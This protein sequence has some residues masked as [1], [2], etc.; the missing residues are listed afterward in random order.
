MLAA[1]GA[2][3]VPLPEEPPDELLVEPDD[4]E[5]GELDGVVVPEEDES[6]SPDLLVLLDVLSEP[7]ERES[8][9]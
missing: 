9:R 5:L 2:L 3:P 1:A 8:V 7:D 6:D 4:E